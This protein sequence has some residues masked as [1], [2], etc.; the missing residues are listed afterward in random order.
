M[1]IFIL[2]F[3]EDRL[4][5]WSKASF[6]L[7]MEGVGRCFFHGLWFQG[8]G[9]IVFFFPPRRL[10]RP[11]RCGGSE[12]RAP[13]P[14]F[15]RQYG[16]RARHRCSC[17]RPSM[18]VTGP[19]P[20]RSLWTWALEAFLDSSENADTDELIFKNLISL[21]MLISRRIRG[22]LVCCISLQHP[23]MSLRNHMFRP[24]PAPRCRFLIYLFV[25]FFS[26]STSV[27]AKCLW[28]QWVRWPRPH[29]LL[30]CNVDGGVQQSE[31]L[32]VRRAV[33]F[34]RFQKMRNI[35]PDKFYIC[36]TA[37]YG[38][39]QAISISCLS[40]QSLPAGRTACLVE[41]APLLELAPRPVWFVLNPSPQ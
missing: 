27:P 3:L 18:T 7:A 36:N 19:G 9:P 12:R 21:W 40:T 23:R 38:L 20:L 15:R 14:G 28:I 13:C 30:R 34:F 1:V 5:M 4:L 41:L 31:N 29:C 35:I 10:L 16:P 39:S 37:S 6:F 2:T 32:L 26:H 25:I 33:F 22:N 17:P 24:E 8:V 11:S